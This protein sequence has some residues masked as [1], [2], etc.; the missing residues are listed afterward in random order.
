MLYTIQLDSGLFRYII[1]CHLAPNEALTAM[2][3]F[4]ATEVEDAWDGISTGET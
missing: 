3:S 1:R 2:L 4:S